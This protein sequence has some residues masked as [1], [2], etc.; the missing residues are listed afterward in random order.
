MLPAGFLTRMER[1][2]GAEF[3]DFLAAYDRPRNVGLRLNPLKT[4]VPPDLSSFGLSPIPW[5]KDG[6]F[7]DSATRPGLSAYH[8]A[9]LYYLQEPSAM[10]PV[11]L[12]D[13]RPGMRVL[14]LCAAPGGKSTQIAAAL[15]GSGLLVAN[16][17]NPK[18]AKILARNI[19]RMAVA[20]ALVLNEHPQRLAQRFPGYFHRIL[21]DAP[22]SG[23]GMFRKEEAALS[24]WSEETVAMCAKRQG[25]I[26]AS[27]A[28]MLCPGG[29]LVY[30][31]CTFSPE[32]N[33]GVISAFL[34]THPDFTMEAVEAPWFA[35]GR[36]DWIADPA[37]G[38]SHAFRLWPHRLPGEGHFAAVLRRAGD[39]ESQDTAC[40]A[41][42]PL[43]PVAAA[44]S[45][46]YDLALPQGGCAAFGDTICLLPP[47]S[48]ALKGLKVLRAGLELGQW[49][50]NRLEPAHAWALWLKSA[51]STVD[52]PADSRE[53]AAY[54]KGETLPGAQK[55]WTLLTV[56][57]LSLGWVKGDGRTLKNHF[58]KALRHLS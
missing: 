5:A 39:G 46:E 48:P 44:F 18:R 53:A 8:E 9:G 40:E 24:D 12:L 1:L 30:S 54:L 43:P 27:A 11:G 45:K 41:L 16:E 17:F 29:R 56:D 3:S 49:K 36:P 47:D 32:E 50:K 22:C 33:E 34:K 6:F 21:V 31:T 14:D 37:P 38:L 35:P 15:H 28:Q 25:E 23:E 26:L 52:V 13:V 7:Y 51:A 10:A 55:G 4:H 58:P 42:S 57:G 20:N 2:M 19:E